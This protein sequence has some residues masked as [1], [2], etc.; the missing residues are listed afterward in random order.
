M[1]YSLNYYF[2]YYSTKY[3]YEVKSNCLKG[4]EVSFRPP[5][6][7]EWKEEREVL[8]DYDILIITRDFFWSEC[9]EKCEIKSKQKCDECMIFG[10]RT[11]SLAKTLEIT[12]AGQK[13]RRSLLK[14]LYV[15]N[16]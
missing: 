5:G 15:Y 8:I 7:G 3:L 11:V 13:W 4:L 12:Q 10:I 14:Y 9:E 2:N 1:E 6:E 16:D